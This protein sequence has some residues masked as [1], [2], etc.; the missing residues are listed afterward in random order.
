LTKT[1]TGSVYA[2]QAMVNAADLSADNGIVHSIDAVVLANETVVD[3]A[4]DNGFTSLTTAVVTAELLPALTNPFATLTVFAP[5]NAAFDQLAADLN[6]DL[7]GVLA[8]SNLADILL[9]QFLELQLMQT[10]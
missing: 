7:N 8:S 4:I 10:E 2:N 6:T 9:Y 1:S 3:I 5:D